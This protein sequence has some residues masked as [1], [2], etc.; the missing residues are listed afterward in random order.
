[1]SWTFLSTSSQLLAYHGAAAAAA[2]AATTTAV[3]RSRKL[4]GLDATAAQ[5]MVLVVCRP[6]ACRCA[7]LL[8]CCRKPPGLDETPVQL[9]VK[10]D[11][12]VTCIAAASV[13][14][15]VCG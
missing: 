9:V 7:V 12:T 13:L 1:L 15:K 4:P 10:G 6:N 3:V 8:L 11:A 2:P 14:A 5:P